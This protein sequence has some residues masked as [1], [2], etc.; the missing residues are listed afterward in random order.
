MNKQEQIEKMTRM[1]CEDDTP[2]GD[3]EDKVNCNECPCYKNKQC[4]LYQ[5]TATSLVKAGY[6]NGADFVSKVAWELADKIVWENHGRIFDLEEINQI[7][8]EALQEYLKG[9]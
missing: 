2:Y 7:L 4:E 9:E 3:E 5:K 6:I 8:N 1:I